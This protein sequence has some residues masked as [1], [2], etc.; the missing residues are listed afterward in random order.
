MKAKHSVVFIAVFLLF[1]HTINAQSQQER[2]KIKG[3]KRVGVWEFY[4][5]QELGLRFDYDSSRIQY[6]RFDTARYPVL[7]DTTWQVRRL[8]R[9]PRVL[10]S[11][12][13][14]LLSLQKTLRYPLQDI[15]NGVSGTVVLTYVIDEQGGK[16]NPVAVI[17]PSKTLAEEV[18]RAVEIMPFVYLPAIYRG[19]RAPT[20][21]A[22]VVRFCFC[23]TA[24]DCNKVSHEQAQL[25]P[26]PPGFVGE[27]IV[28]TR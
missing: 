28:T 15:R 1:A 4:D 22:F 24:D 11:K 18:Y 20:K 6:A 23:K 8:N 2:G 25:V 16:T 14:M 12:S 5:F 17:T 13:E 19:K 10:G 3:D 26:K 9:A 27:I 21:I 7:V